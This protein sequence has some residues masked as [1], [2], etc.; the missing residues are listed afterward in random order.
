MVWSKAQENPNKNVP[1]QSGDDEDNEAK[2][3]SDKNKKIIQEK[4]TFAEIKKTKEFIYIV[5]RENKIRIDFHG[6]FISSFI[7]SNIFIYYNSYFYLASSC[8]YY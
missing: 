3:K 5:K 7:F 8:C 1:S 2:S 6:F 4:K